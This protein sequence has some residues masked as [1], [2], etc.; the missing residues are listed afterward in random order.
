[1]M[2]VTVTSETLGEL[3]LP[4]SHRGRGTYNRPRPQSPEADITHHAGRESLTHLIKRL[5]GEET[6]QLTRRL[7]S[8]RRRKAHHLCSLIF[9]QRCRDTGT[10]PGFIRQKRVFRTA[11]SHRIYDRMERAML[12]ERIHWTRRDLAKTDND[13]LI[14]HLQLSGALEPTLWDKIDGLTYSKFEDD[15]TSQT[16]RQKRKFNILQPPDT[17]CYSRYCTNCHQPF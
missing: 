3:P 5:Y 10:I 11:Q 6:F 13:L 15:L 14:L 9:L 17:Q 7:E 8:L 16:K 12:R 2:P 1:M 4:R